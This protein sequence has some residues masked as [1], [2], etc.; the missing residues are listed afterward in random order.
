MTLRILR[1][2]GRGRTWHRVRADGT[3]LC[4]VR[5]IRW[6]PQQGEAVTCKQCQRSLFAKLSPARPI[7]GCFDIEVWP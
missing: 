6:L 5:R 7:Y 4:N 3:S 2:A 1:S